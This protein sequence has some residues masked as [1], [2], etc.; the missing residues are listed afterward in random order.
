MKKTL[1]FL[2]AASVMVAC[3]GEAPAGDNNDADTTA[4]TADTTAV[5]EQEPEQAMVGD[6]MSF[7]AEISP[8]GA[9][10]AGDMIASFEGQDSAVVKFEAPIIEACQKKGCWMTLDMGDSSEVMVR[11]KDYGFFVPLDAGGKTTIVEGSIYRTEIGVDELKHYAEDAGK[12]QE[13]IDAI[14]E[15]EQTLAFEATGVLIK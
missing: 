5:V 2:A 4:T 14:T 3:G 9:L 1:L 10:T 11:F 6:Y 13:E 12:S 15:P 8:D 7:G